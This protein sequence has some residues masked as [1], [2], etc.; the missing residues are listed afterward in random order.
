M[1]KARLPLVI[2]PKQVLTRNKM[3]M[4]LLTMVGGLTY[5]VV[6]SA[7]HP[8]YKAPFEQ[9]APVPV[10]QPV[11]ANTPV[12]PDNSTAAALLA[13]SSQSASPSTGAAL[14]TNP[15][16]KIYPA[17]AAPATA[18]LVYPVQLNRPANIDATKL[19]HSAVSVEAPQGVDSVD[20]TI[21]LL[22]PAARDG[23]RSAVVAPPFLMCTVEVREHGLIASQQTVGCTQSGDGRRPSMLMEFGQEVPNEIP[24]MKYWLSVQVDGY[25]QGY[26][27]LR[28][29]MEMKGLLGRT[30]GR[31]KYESVTVAE[32]NK[33][34]T[35]IAFNIEDDDFVVT[36]FARKQD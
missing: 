4:A 31:R 6:N 26:P 12:A 9:F 8:T 16:A 7:V 34:Q 29:Q 25:R 10:Q 17:N 35:A 36:I 14:R 33:K 11:A 23:D 30:A 28:T 22:G 15:G 24:N 19:P 27:I 13:P 3:K 18:Q 21:P 32:P 20:K 2:T 1:H 5:A